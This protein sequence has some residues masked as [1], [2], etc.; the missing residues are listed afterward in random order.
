MVHKEQAKYERPKNKFTLITLLF[1]MWIILATPIFWG[2]GEVESKASLQAKEREVHAVLHAVFLPQYN[3]VACRLLCW[4]DPGAQSSHGYPYSPS[5]Q[6]WSMHQV[7]WPHCHLYVPTWHISM[8]TLTNSLQNFLR[9]VQ[10]KIESFDP[11]Q[12][13]HKL[14]KIIFHLAAANSED[15]LQSICQLSTWTRSLA[16]GHLF[17]TLTITN[18]ST[19]FEPHRFLLET[20]ST[21]LSNSHVRLFKIFGLIILLN[22]LFAFL[23]TVP[24]SK[25]LQFVARH[26][27]TWLMPPVKAH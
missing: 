14:L 6:L 18:P 12:L 23:K 10:P 26:S 8:L 5:N 13:P 7:G 24:T 3:D 21:N 17:V 2:T 15:F 27:H 20:F 11:I 25:M 9:L 4:H 16:Q 1:W 19:H 22:H